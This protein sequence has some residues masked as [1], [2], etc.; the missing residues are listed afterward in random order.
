MH[1]C[2]F[3]LVIPDQVFGSETAA[4]IVASNHHDGL[5]RSN[6]AQVPEQGQRV[7]TEGAHLLRAL[8]PASASHNFR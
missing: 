3:V 5:P 4:L 2:Q 8:P 7:A 1:N 6:M